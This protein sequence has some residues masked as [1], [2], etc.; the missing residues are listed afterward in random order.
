MD[1]LSASGALV[2]YDLSVGPID[3]KFANA[4]QYLLYGASGDGMRLQ[5]ICIERG[6]VRLF[7]PR[8]Q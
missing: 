5:M 3:P 6:H 2:A 1:L 7:M 4:S 8:H